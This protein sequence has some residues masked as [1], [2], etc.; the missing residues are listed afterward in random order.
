MVMTISVESGSRLQV[1]WQAMISHKSAVYGFVFGLLFSSGCTRSNPSVSLILPQKVR[2][3]TLLLSEIQAAE[4]MADV[5]KCPIV[6]EN[7]TGK[8]Q[9]LKL[10]G[11]GC[12]CY[13]VTFEGRKLPKG[14]PLEIGVNET[15]LLNVDAGPPL[16][17]SLQDYQARFEFQSA[18]DGR[19]EQNVLCELQVYRDL[20]VFPLVLVCETDLGV[21]QGLTRE[22]TIERIYRSEDGVTAEPTIKHLPEGVSVVK[23]VRSVG[24]IE[25]ETGIWKTVWTS[26][27]SVQVAGDL[28]A[29]G[30]RETYEVEFMN[31]EDGTIIDSA[32][33]QLVR[34]ARAPI[35][36]PKQIQFGRIPLGE[37]RRRTI[38]L[39]HSEEAEFQLSL[40]ESQLPENVSVM[41][42]EETASRFRV[43][44]EI[45]G[46][47][48]GD[49]TETLQLSTNLRKQ[50]T[51]EVELKAIFKKPDDD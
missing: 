33:M 1:R 5:I 40:E 32:Q 4:K 44:V 14:E 27:L 51:V 31:H 23:T 42:P 39:T 16:T 50:P 25:L 35:L 9:T 49:W 30:K 8:V 26:L 37:K 28:S 34:R 19:I 46:L 45:E 20:K 18:A 3:Q 6:V 13:G 11:T 24:P 43:E 47:E 10:V 29:T 15:V 38:F 2:A 36:F 17:E 21:T 48:L 7:S 41:I 12:S 22:L